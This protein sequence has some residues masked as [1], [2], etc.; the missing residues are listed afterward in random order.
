M[1]EFSNKPSYDEIF[2]ELT[3]VQMTNS[4][5]TTLKLNFLKVKF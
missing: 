5:L 3:I 2:N 1:T 4:K